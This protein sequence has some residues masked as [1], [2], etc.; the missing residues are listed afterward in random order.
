MPKAFLLASSLRDQYVVLARLDIGAILAD[1]LADG[2][3]LRLV[4]LFQ[5]GE[6]RDLV[7]AAFHGQFGEGVARAGCRR[8]PEHLDVDLRKRRIDVAPL[9]RV[10]FEAACGAGT[11]FASAR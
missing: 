6:G 1:A 11:S 10:G 3:V 5:L 9:L 7:A 4:R 8:R 2:A